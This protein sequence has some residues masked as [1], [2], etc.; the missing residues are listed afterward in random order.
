MFQRV[1]T[2]L[3]LA[4]LVIWVALWAPKFVMLAVLVLAAARCADELVRMF[5]EIRARDRLAVA[6]LSAAV[7]ASALHGAMALAVVLAVALCVWLFACLASPESVELAARR[8]ALG[9]LALAY[10]ANLIAMLVLLF[11]RDELAA[12]AAF[13]TGRAALLALFVMV[14]FGDTG[15]YFAG[16]ALGRHK[17]YELVSPKKTVEGGIGGLLAS[18]GGGAITATWLLPQIPMLH[19]LLLGAVCGLF[20][21]VGDFSESLFKRATGTKDSGHIL[22]GHGV[23]LDRVDGVLFAGPVL[24]AYLIWLGPAA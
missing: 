8:G 5:P 2:G 3:I 14:F 13:D 7:A 20:G 21:Q 6:L 19:G 18:I 23:L 24:L 1:A 9:A 16:R 17:L 10:T 4:P 11:R 12:G 22:P 15:A